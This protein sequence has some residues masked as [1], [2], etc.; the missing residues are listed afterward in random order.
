MFCFVTLNNFTL[1]FHLQINGFKA[2]FHMK[3][4]IFILFLSL[5]FAISC[6]DNS[7]EKVDEIPQSTFLK[8]GNGKFSFN[9]YAPLSD[10][11][12]NVYTYLP[13]EGATDL[14]L[15]FVMHGNSR[16]VINNCGYWNESARNFK[17]IVICPEFNETDFPGSANYQNGMM[18]TGGQFADS[19][20]WTYNLIEEI[21][22]YLKENNVT[23]YEKY[24]IYGFSAGGQFVHRYALYTDPKRASFIIAGGSGWYTLPNYSENY[25]Y[26]LSNSPF[27]EANLNKKFQLP[28]VVMIGEN[29]TNPNDSDL[30]KTV[31]AMRQGNHRYDRAKNFYQIATNK[32]NELGVSF[33]W[34]FTTVPGVGHSSES[35]APVAAELFFNSLNN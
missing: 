19:S 14:P 11:P 3:N 2:L 21:F 27:I 4:Y 23:T 7:E 35:I 17:F 32:A 29:D 34:T 22:S 25:P 10:K 1:T 28:L 8:Y 30:R 31:Q 18:F 5:F 6:E 20:K 9:Y 24:G 13:V 12:I 15:I 26:G 33:D 16:S